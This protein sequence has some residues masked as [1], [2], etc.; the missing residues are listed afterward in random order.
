MIQ[1]KAG[2]RRLTEHSREPQSVARRRLQEVQMRSHIGAIVVIVLGVAFLLIN[3]DV[4]PVAELKALLAQWWPLILI[5][6]GLLALA[7]PHRH[8][9]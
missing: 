3:L 4:A 1:V 6:V 5:I 7:R 9:R 8:A 2:R